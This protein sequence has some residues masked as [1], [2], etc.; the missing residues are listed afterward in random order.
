LTSSFEA[1]APIT[2]GDYP[3]DDASWEPASPSRRR[4]VRST[5]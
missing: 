4:R 5:S 2:R 3:Q 1:V